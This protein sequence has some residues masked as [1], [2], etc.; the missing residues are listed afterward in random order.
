MTTQELLQ[1]NKRLIDLRIEIENL[2]DKACED[3]RNIATDQPV[4]YPEGEWN[5]PTTGQTIT[6]KKVD[7]EENL[8]N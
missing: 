2:F 6:P 7:T 8:E 5:D 3:I 1:I 4:V